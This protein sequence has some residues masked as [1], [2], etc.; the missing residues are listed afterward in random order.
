M[1][2]RTKNILENQIEEGFIKKAIDFAQGVGDVVS[3]AMSFVPG[4]NIIGS[5]I[6]A[7]SAGVDVA[8]GDHGDAAFRA[9]SAVGGLIPGVGGVMKAGKLAKTAVTAGRAAGKIGKIGKQAKV[10]GKVV[11]RAAG[12]NF[13]SNTP[14]GFA[15]G[16]PQTLPESHGDNMQYLDKV[17]DTV[18]NMKPDTSVI[19]QQ[20]NANA[21]P[22]D[23][24]K[25]IKPSDRPV[26][27]IKPRLFKT[28]F[29]PKNTGSEGY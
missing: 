2:M 10:A 24:L 7:I 8:Q 3:G 4:L 5:G 16:R 19:R 12:V 15:A 29:N 14:G 22:G 11:N 1:L 9:A 27:K 23:T 13:G 28:S 17:K 18:A 21:N 6:D 26:G 20:V 25:S